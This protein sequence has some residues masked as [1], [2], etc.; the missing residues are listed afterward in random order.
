MAKSDIFYVEW[1]VHRDDAMEKWLRPLL[2]QLWAFLSPKFAIQHGLEKP[3][4][5]AR[6][7]MPLRGIG[8]RDVTE[9]LIG[10]KVPIKHKES[11]LAPKNL[12]RRQRSRPFPKPEKSVIFGM[13]GKQGTTWKGFGK[14]KF[15]K[16]PKVTYYMY[17]EALITMVRWKS[18]CEHYLLSYEHFY[19][20]NLPSKMGSKN[21]CLNQ[22]LKCCGGPTATVTSLKVTWN[23]GPDNAPQGK[24]LSARNYAAYAT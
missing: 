23:E 22:H 8:N 14:L 18:D 15:Y 19:L 5:T 1:S 16:W 3:V 13:L 12:L 7:G 24:R 11:D 4:F 2:A 9:K 6:F 20:Q 17:N 21:P 10:M